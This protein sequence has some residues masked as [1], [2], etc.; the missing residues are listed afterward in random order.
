MSNIMGSMERRDV[1]LVA[2]AILLTAV[3][4]IFFSLGSS[5]ELTKELCEDSDGVWNVSVCE[6]QSSFQCPPGYYCKSWKA[7]EKGV[8]RA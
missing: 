6:C 8:C 5:R 2:A 4:L 7:G 3:V 1:L